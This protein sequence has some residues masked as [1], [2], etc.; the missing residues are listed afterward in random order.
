MRTF[1]WL[2]LLYHMHHLLL[3]S[4]LVTWKL[5]GCRSGASIDA[6]VQADPERYPTLGEMRRSAS[7]SRE[8]MQQGGDEYVY[9]QD[10]LDQ[11]WTID[12]YLLIRLCLEDRL[13]DLY[14][15]AA[16]SLA[17]LLP[18]ATGARSAARARRCDPAERGADA[19]PACRRPRRRRTATTT[20]TRSARPFCTARSRNCARADL[21]RDRAPALSRTSTR[22]LLDLVRDRARGQA[23]RG[24]RTSA[25]AGRGMYPARDHARGTRGGP[26]DG[27]ARER[28]S[29][30]PL[31][32]LR[33]APARG[34][35]PSRR[36][37]PRPPD[38]LRRHR[39]GL[40]RRPAE[41]ERR[42]LAALDPFAETPRRDRQSHGAG[43]AAVV[44][45]H[46]RPRA[47]RLRS[48]VASS[49]TPRASAAYRPAIQLAL[50][51]LLERLSGSNEAELLES[52]IRPF[53]AAAV[54]SAFGFPADDW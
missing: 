42:A 48:G 46:R 54:A 45:E 13:D 37:R 53:P 52:V 35:S 18:P 6:L 44:P 39:R 22:W 50:D 15:E 16:R 21:V 17:P 33:A 11:Y 25:V 34:S 47:Q 30:R 3:P 10:W 38:L 51:H 40:P 14:A 5:S 1:A 23:R 12:E 26:G 9:S 2:T 29:R 27:F 4:L 24:R 28:R 41:C 36:Q 19:P 8:Q 49:F 43:E 20:F 32:V 31:P 7:T